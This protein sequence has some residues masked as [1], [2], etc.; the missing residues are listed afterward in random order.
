MNKTY[1]HL[2]QVRQ[3]ILYLFV[4]GSLLFGSCR[5]AEK[6]IQSNFQQATNIRMEAFRNGNFAQSRIKLKELLSE[7]PNDIEVRVINA[8]T[9]LDE[10][11]LELNKDTSEQGQGLLNKLTNEVQIINKGLIGDRKTPTW[12]EPTLHNAYAT[13]L[14]LDAKRLLAMEEEKTEERMGIVYAQSFAAEQIAQNVLNYIQGIAKDSLT[15]GLLRTKKAGLDNMIAAKY[16]QL[17]AISILLVA[18]NEAVIAEKSQH[19]DQTYDFLTTSTILTKDA[20][21]AY[22]FWNFDAYK[23]LQLS[24]IETLVADQ[25]VA[26]LGQLCALPREADGKLKAEIRKKVREKQQQIIDSAKKS[27]A[28]NILSLHLAKKEIKMDLTKLKSWQDAYE[29]ACK[30]KE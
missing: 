14:L 6:V 7:Q 29:P 24:D 13:A 20:P 27:L 4:T 9:Y 26:D 22:S 2:I 17:E 30:D 5:S 10:Y 19:I 25:Y 11:T 23:Y 8:I 21:P 12:V 3:F 28:H 15:P 1:R 16:G 18:E